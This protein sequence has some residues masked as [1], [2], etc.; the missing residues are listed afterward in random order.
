MAIVMWVNRMSELNSHAPEILINVPIGHFGEGGTVPFTPRY[1]KRTTGYLD[2]VQIRAI[3]EK[4]VYFRD[5][6]NRKHTVL[7][8]IWKHGKLTAELK[9]RIEATFDKS[10]LQDL[11]RPKRRTK[12]TIAR[13]KGS[14]PFALI[15]GDKEPAG[16]PMTDFAAIFVDETKGGL[17][18]DEA[19]EGARHIVSEMVSKDADLRKTLHLTMWNERI[20]DEFDLAPADAAIAGEA[21]A[22]HAQNLLQ[23]GV[24]PLYACD[25]DTG[26]RH[27]Y[28]RFPFTVPAARSRYRVMHSRDKGDVVGYASEIWIDTRRSLLTSIKLPTDA[29]FD[30]I[31]VGTTIKNGWVRMQKGHACLPVHSTEELISVNGRTERNEIH[32]SQCRALTGRR[33]VQF[34]ATART[35]VVDGPP[36]G[37]RFALECNESIDPEKLRAGQRLTAELSSEIEHD[38]KVLFLRSSPVEIRLL[39]LQGRKAKAFLQF[40]LGEIAVSASVTARLLATPDTVCCVMNHHTDTASG[41]VKIGGD[42]KRPGL[43]TIYVRGLWLQLPKGHRTAWVTV[44]SPRLLKEER[45]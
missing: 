23:P 22:G 27:R 6:A 9:T 36:A 25:W 35:R 19:L 14:L 31:S 40:V 12:A 33:T 34:E 17:V 20:A 41:A 10:E 7:A 44:A 37:V 38:G 1:R 15:C 28:A 39:H 4:F 42:I 45:H 13:E 2:E 26:S 24:S 21:F 43:G 8:S 3:G 16:V 5:L 18:M 11:Y 32:F 29:A 30:G